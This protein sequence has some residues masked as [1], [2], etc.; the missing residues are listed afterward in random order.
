[1]ANYC[2]LA[3]VHL[4]PQIT[5]F[6]C[7]PQW[8]CKQ[9]SNLLWIVSKPCAPDEPYFFFFFFYWLHPNFVIIALNLKILHFIDKLGIPVIFRFVPILHVIEI[10]SLICAGVYW[11][12]IHCF[13]SLW[14]FFFSWGHHHCR[15][16]AAELSTSAI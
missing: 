3:P 9:Y 12:I 16:R 6:W 7:N 4:L 10:G 13:T 2:S 15:W 8:I 5:G 1:M 11:F 14:R